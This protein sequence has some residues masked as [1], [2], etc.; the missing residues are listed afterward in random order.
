LEQAQQ[1]RHL[2]A[3]R[4]LLQ[5]LLNT[6]LLQVLEVAAELEAAEVLAGIALL[7][8]GNLQVEVRQRKP[9]F[10]QP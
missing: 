2:I 1:A 8:L 7:Y 5:P 3:L 4:Q 10:L 9:P 6:L